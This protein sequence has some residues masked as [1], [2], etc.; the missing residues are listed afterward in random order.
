MSMTYRNSLATFNPVM[1]EGKTG[2]AELEKT[3]CQKLS[4]EMMNKTA[5][6]SVHEGEV[7]LCIS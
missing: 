1:S 4:F 5:R 6:V 7:Y 3:D 2:P